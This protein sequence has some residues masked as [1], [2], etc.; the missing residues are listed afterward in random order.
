MKVIILAFRTLRIS[1]YFLVFTHSA[2]DCVPHT[3]SLDIE[4]IFSASRRLFP[5]YRSLKIARHSTAWHSSARFSSFCNS[6]VNH[7]LLSSSSVSQAWQSSF[8]FPHSSF[9]FL[10][11]DSCRCADVWYGGRS[12]NG[13]EIKTGRLSNLGRVLTDTTLQTSDYSPCP[14]TA[15]CSGHFLYVSGWEKWSWGERGA[16]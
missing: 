6:K 15:A 10:F 11:F 2:T 13:R 12:S 16:V 7:P 9:P 4:L 3:F 5:V 1:F 8:S 14:Q